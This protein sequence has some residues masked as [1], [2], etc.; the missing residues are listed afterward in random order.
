MGHSLTWKERPR[1][2]PGP[3]STLM[4]HGSPARP[5]PRRVSAWAALQKPHQGCAEFEQAPGRRG[6]DP[7]GRRHMAAQVLFGG[8]I[9]GFP[10]PP[11]SVSASP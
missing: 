4:W 2:R 9:R 5:G 11:P 7:A 1:R 8:L 6:V 3:S 10:A